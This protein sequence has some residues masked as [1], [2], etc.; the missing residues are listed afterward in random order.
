MPARRHRS[1][2]YKKKQVRTPGGRV[3]RHYKEKRKGGAVCA[4]CGRPLGGVPRISGG[5]I[6]SLPRSSR[7]P[8]RPFAGYFCV[9]CSRRF[10]LEKVRA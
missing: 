4:L 8:N 6:G 5:R 1:R 10:L 7:M 2:T 3:A 9:A